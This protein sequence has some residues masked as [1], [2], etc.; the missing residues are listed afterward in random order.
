[1][2]DSEKTSSSSRNLE[3]LAWWLDNAFEV[4]G[5]RF[6]IGFD[7]LIGLVPGLGDLVGT[8]LSAYIVAAAARRGVPGSV[9]TRM[10]L[11]VGIEAVVGALPLVGDLFD[12][13]W[14]ANQRNVELVRR[15]ET[16]PRPTQ[17]QS[18]VVVALWIVAFVAAVGVVAAL[19]FALLRWLWLEL[20]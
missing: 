11:N 8:A 4:P 1:M 12:A 17:R 16:G 15:Y 18:R 7:A 13:W 3:R 2:V 5:T 14:K 9:L 10:A 19:V 6:R 20:A